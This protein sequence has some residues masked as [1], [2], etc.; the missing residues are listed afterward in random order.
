[1]HTWEATACARTSTGRAGRLAASPERTAP[2]WGVVY[3]L[4]VADCPKKAFAEQMAQP[5]SGPSW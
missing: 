4:S 2:A 5:Q 3:A 1:M